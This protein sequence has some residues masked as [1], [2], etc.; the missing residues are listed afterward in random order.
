VLDPL[1]T[2][3]DLTARGITW[4]SPGED[5]LVGVFLDEASAAVRTAAGVPI[6]QATSTVSLRGSCDRWLRLPGVPV[7]AVEDVSIDG[8]TVA[9]WKLVDSMLWR[10]CG[11][12]LTDEPSVVTETQTHGLVEVPVDI[13]GM[14][15]ALVGMALRQV[16]SSTDGTGATPL[17]Q[18]VVSVGIDDYRVQF[19]QDGDRNLTVFTLPERVERSLR[20]RFGGG[21]SVVE[22]L[23]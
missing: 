19:R 8:G 9:D 18:D 7:T 16:H 4:T 12:Q 15:C 13:V 6:S 1:A 2:T 20:T 22:L 5:D 23:S 10:R 21:A 3:A 14:V 11:W 17:P